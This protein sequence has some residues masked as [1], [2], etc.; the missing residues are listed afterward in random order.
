MGRAP[1]TNRCAKVHFR[2]ESKCR[3]SCQENWLDFITSVTKCYNN[4]PKDVGVG[5]YEMFGRSVLLVQKPEYVNQ[6]LKNHVGHYLWGGIAAASTCFF[7]DK[8]MF[9]V[10]DE[11]WR[12]LR[13]V[14]SP[15]LRSQIDVP[16][17]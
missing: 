5:Y 11:E 2:Y 1:I 12:Q 6:I 8:V 4:I 14:M 10:E 9:V 17:P 15:E 13:R 7:G 16:S 3:A